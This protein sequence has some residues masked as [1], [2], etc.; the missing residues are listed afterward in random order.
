[1]SFDLDPCRVFAESGEL[2]A[3]GFVREQEDDGLLVEADHFTGSWLEEGDAAV[4][5]VMSAVRGEVT[6]DAVVTLSVARR[7]GLGGLRLREAVQKRSAVRVPT[8]LP[9]RVTH[10][11]EGRERIE[12]DEPLDVVVIDVSAHGLRLQCGQ[13]IEAGTDLELELTA[14]GTPM[15][16]I[17]HVLRSMDNRQG[18]AHGCTFVRMSEKDEDD[19]FTFVLAEQRRQRAQRMDALEG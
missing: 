19:L 11:Y 4:V 2:L 14:T 12:L 16:V 3:E 10:R 5:Q 9:H 8:S 17:V 1:M 7:I 18:Y 15:T 6:Y 13:Q